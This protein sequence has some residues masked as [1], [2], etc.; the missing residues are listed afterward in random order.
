MILL[1]KPTFTNLFDDFFNDLKHNANP[2][3]PISGAISKGRPS[4][5]WNDVILKNQF[6]MNKKIIKGIVKEII[7]NI[8]SVFLIENLLFMIPPSHIVIFLI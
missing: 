3:S 5:F 7:P 8:F 4:N 2:I 1:I 6:K